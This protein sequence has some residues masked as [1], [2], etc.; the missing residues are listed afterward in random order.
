MKSQGVIDRIFPGSLPSASDLHALLTSLSENDSSAERLAARA[1]E[2]SSSVFGGKVFL[3]GLVE[4]GNVCRN[5]CYYCGI[6]KSNSNIHRYVLSAEEIFSCCAAGYRRGFRTFVLQGGENPGMGDDFLCD[7]IKKIKRELTGCAVTLSLG[8]RGYDSFKR[9]YDAGADRYLLRHEA[10]DE[11]YFYKLHP[12]PSAGTEAT[13]CP[14]AGSRDGAYDVSSTT[15]HVRR[16]ASLR[17]LKEIGYQVGA[18]FMVGAPGQTVGHIAE[19]LE[20]IAELR[21]QMVGIGPYMP[22]PDTPF[23]KMRDAFWTPESKRRM[24]LGLLSILRL[25]D[26]CLLLPSTTA[27]NTLAEGARYEGIMAGANVIMP[28]ISPARARA[29]YELY[30]GKVTDGGESGEGLDELEKS[31]AAIGYEADWSRGDYCPHKGCKEK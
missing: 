13:A 3:R 10:A 26:P 2:V 24:T 21:P 7:L 16:M 18:G 6:R 22:H 12:R 27:L 15:N 25:L 28:N 31:L 9:L 23:G 17:M 19:D 20:F 8:E 29:A 5:D 30:S 1:R 11:D 4:I 14:D